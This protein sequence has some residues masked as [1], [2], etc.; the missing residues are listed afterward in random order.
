MAAMQLCIAH[1][2]VHARFSYTVDGSMAT[3]A[4]HALSRLALSLCT[5]THRYSRSSCSEVNP[6]MGHNSCE[7]QANDLHVIHLQVMHSTLFLHFLCSQ[8]MH[9]ALHVHQN[10]ST[11]RFIHNAWCAKSMSSPKHSRH[12]ATHGHCESCS[13]QV[14]LNAGHAQRTMLT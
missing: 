11:T 10:S 8:F 2:E 3:M 1:S 5:C 12:H 13:M 9:H 4:L 7:L 14:M 6:Q